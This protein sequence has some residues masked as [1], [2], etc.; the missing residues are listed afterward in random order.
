[1]GQT[2]PRIATPAATQQILKQHGLTLKKSL[3]QNFMTDPNILDVMVRAAQLKSNHGVLEVGPGIGALTQVLAEHT[4]QVVAVEIDNRLSAV[5]KQTLQAYPNVVI[6]EADILQVDLDALHKEYFQ[7]HVECVSV[8]ANL[9][10]YITT[11]IL[12]RF[13]EA[14]FPF[15]NMVV[16]VQKEVGDRLAAKPA[17]KD[18]GALSVAVQFHCH[19]E[20]VA[21][22]SRNV[23]LPR[24]NVDSAIIRLSRHHEPPVQ[25]KDEDF[26]FQVVK[27]A[28]A[29]RRKTLMNNLLQRFYDRK[30][31]D[32]LGALL[33]ASG[34]DPIRRGETLSI[35]EFAAL[36]EALQQDLL[37]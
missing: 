5:L 8:I 36:S 35:A 9:P 25:V 21:N 27:A 2:M 14:R 1:M 10:Y 7:H 32:H 23:F 4:K 6:R 24:P 11:P 18:Y 33:N 37:S 29:Q 31:R 13:L 17:N 34:I 30:D 20:K 3:G 15:T 28:F 16:L 19:V 26:F 12:M 22:V